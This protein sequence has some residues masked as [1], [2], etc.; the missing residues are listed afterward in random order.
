MEPGDLQAELIRISKSWEK[1]GTNPDS[2]RYVFEASKEIVEQ[3]HEIYS[4]LKP[5]NLHQSLKFGEDLGRILAPSL[6]MSYYLGF[7]HSA[8]RLP[9]EDAPTYLQ[10]ASKPITDLA[11]EL[12]KTLFARGDI[13]PSQAKKYKFDIRKLNQDLSTKAFKLG[14]VDFYKL[15][16]LPVPKMEISSSNLLNPLEVHIFGVNF[17]S[18]QLEKEGVRITQVNR[19]ILAKP[20]LIAEV[21]NKKSYI[22]VRTKLH[23]NKGQLTPR[24][25]SNFRDLAHAQNAVPYFV[26]VRLVNADGINDLEMSTP[27]RFSGYYFLSDG[28]LELTPK[29]HLSTP[30]KLFTYNKSGDI[31]GYVE[32]GEDNK[33]TIVY[34]KNSDVFSSTMATGFVFSN[35]LD[36]DSRI[37]FSRWAKLPIGW[38]ERHK[39]VFV[40]AYLH[41]L[42]QEKASK[43]SNSNLEVLKYLPPANLPPL[44][45]ELSIEVINIFRNYLIQ[46]SS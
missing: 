43:T 41:F 9:L 15:Q 44:E 20:Q 1:Y 37:I 46:E 38:T 40:T 39:Q 21:H 14:E 35:T 10:A 11:G 4:I 18:E 23:P 31:A 25:H 45:R 33:S 32:V 8:G 2:S 22:W 24:E 6:L 13:S 5:L 42:Y 7:E 3:L 34:S 17:V 28:L 36:E 16:G 27:T 12:I 29:G 30:T 19:G 26:S